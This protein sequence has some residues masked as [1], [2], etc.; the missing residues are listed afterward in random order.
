MGAGPSMVELDWDAPAACP[1]HEQI[2]RQVEE[3]LGRSL[4]GGAEDEMSFQVVVRPTAASGFE[5]RL[6]V[7]VGGAERHRMLV[8]DDCVK[9]AE[10]AVLLIAMTIDPEAQG[11]DVA[12][13]AK[14]S[15]T[16]KPATAPAEPRQPPESPT[17]RRAVLREM[18]AGPRVSVGTGVLP[19][20]GVGFGAEAG[21]KFGSSLRV[22]GH[23]DY[24]PERTETVSRGAAELEMISGGLRGCWI[25]GQRWEL[26]VCV[27]P[28]L[29]RISGSGRNLDENRS[30]SDRWSAVGVEAR[31]QVPLARWLS[32]QTGVEFDAALER[33]AFEV[34]G[35]GEVHRSA[36]WAFRAHAG[37]AVRLGSD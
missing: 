25:G 30:A 21:A 19:E 3:S 11:R 31:L 26:G 28:Q 8:H 16:P 12:P 15:A 13:E 20:W 6:E 22:L 2:V 23:L 36:A 4:G 1:E 9:L 7:R 18:C 29:A 24:W 35:F 17:P 27:G 5:M 32:V 14:G 37:L 10:A 34:H 33:P